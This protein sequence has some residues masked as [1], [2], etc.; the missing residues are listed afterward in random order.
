MT[1][2]TRSRGYPQDPIA[3]E[4]RRYNSEDAESMPKRLRPAARGNGSCI[5]ITFGR[6]R[7]KIRHAC[8][9]HRTQYSST[10]SATARERLAWRPAKDK[11]TEDDE[12]QN[13]EDDVHRPRKGRCPFRPELA[14]EHDTIPENQQ[15]QQ[16][17][18]R[19]PESSDRGIGASGAKLAGA[20]LRRH[21]KHSRMA[22]P[23]VAATR[24]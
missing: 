13:E 10:C 14:E 4:I 9:K 5:L 21:R 11:S 2:Y 12:A 17:T 16:R 8:L 20:R 22:G 19:D 3:T 15:K 7:R 1:G 23:A 6:I 18:R 24:W